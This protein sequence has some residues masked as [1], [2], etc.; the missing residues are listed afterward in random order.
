M[1]LPCPPPVPAVPQALG[2][3]GRVGLQ[4]GASRAEMGWQSGKASSHT[5]QS[6]A[7]QTWSSRPP[8]APQELSTGHS[9]VLQV[10]EELEPW[11]GWCQ[12][13][14]QVQYQV[15]Q[16]PEGCQVSSGPHREKGPRRWLEA[17]ASFYRQDD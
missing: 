11:E 16:E 8:P 3:K 1:A 10:L 9:S 6:R 13:Q 15:C 12:A 17:P 2:S 14:C 4:Q 7:R 5:L